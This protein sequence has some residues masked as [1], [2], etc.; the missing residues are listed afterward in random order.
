M[1]PA[2]FDYVRADSADEA[3]AALAEHGDDAK[4]LAGGMSLIPLMKLRLATPTVLVDVG[5]V[6]D[7]S[8]VRDAGDHVADRRADPSPRPRDQRPARARVR[9]AARPSPPRSATTRCATAARSAARSRTAIPRPTSRRCC[10]RSTPRSWCAGRAG[11][12]TIAAADFFLGFLETVAR[13]RRAAHRDPR[14]E[15]RRRTGSTTRSSTGG[16]RTGRSSARSR[17][18]RTARRTSR[19]S[20]WAARRCARRRSSRRWRSGASVA[21]AAAARGRRHRAAE[22]PQRVA[23]VPRAPRARARAPRRSRLRSRLIARSSSSPPG[24]GSRFGGADAQA[25]RSSSAA[26]RWSRTRSTPRRRA[27]AR[28]GDGRRATGRARSRRASP[29]R[30]GGAQPRAG[31]GHRVEPPGRPA[32]ARALRP[33][34]TPSC[35]GLADQPRVGADAY[36]RLAAAYDDG[37]RL[38]VATYGGAR[39]NPVAHRPRALVGDRPARGLAPVTKGARVLLRRYA[40]CHRGAVRRHRR[41]DSDVDTRAPTSPP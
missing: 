36:R 25:A 21:D 9:R 20:T 41:P 40:R 10:S 5:R 11:E 22:R 12:R 1:I 27:A 4:L 2:A 32:R 6:R 29:R 35:V 23:R 28:R 37:A 17:R 14:P 7:L 31:S 19:S 26:A 16:P 13:A 34:S 38:A 33:R 15:D 8:Y 30:R 24:R 3:V 18:G 39:G